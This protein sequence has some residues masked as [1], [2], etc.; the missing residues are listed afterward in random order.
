MLLIVII[1]LGY[2]MQRMSSS[3][4]SSDLSKVIDRRDAVRVPTQVVPSLQCHIGS[5]RQLTFETLGE[6]NFLPAV[7]DLI[8]IKDWI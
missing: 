1:F 3:E 2:E 7:C 6:F 8:Q 4:R 5:D